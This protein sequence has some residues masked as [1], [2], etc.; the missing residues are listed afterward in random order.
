MPQ[1]ATS[2]ATSDSRPLTVEEMWAWDEC[3]GAQ[4]SQMSVWGRIVCDHLFGLPAER[5]VAHLAHAL[6]FYP[7]V[8]KTPA[9][10][11]AE[12]PMTDEE[13]ERRCDA[14]KNNPAVGVT[15]NA[16][17]NSDP[18]AK[19]AAEAILKVL[20]LFSDADDRAVFLGLVFFASPALRFIG[21]PQPERSSAFT[22][23]AIGAIVCAE[24]EAV[25]PALAAIK[26][27]GCGH[28]TPTD[29]G[30]VV[31][32]ALERVSRSEHR[33]VVLGFLL[34]RLADAGRRKP[35]EALDDLDPVVLREITAEVQKLA[36]RIGSSIETDEGHDADETAMR[37]FLN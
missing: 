37:E 30:E 21:W 11:F 15:M 7:L 17:A 23:E 8:P 29:I 9:G 28:T 16:I 18:S 13:W 34:E 12:R 2:A 6:R 33:A 26:H 32:R 35:H 3:L 22:A 19:D 14:I 1:K 36:A 25:I 31:L 5:R 27:L 4:V 10:R 24:R 20:E